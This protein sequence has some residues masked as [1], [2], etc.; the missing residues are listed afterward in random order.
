VGD[1]ADPPAMPGQE[2]VPQADA[3]ERHLLDLDRRA[4]F[5]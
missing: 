2:V 5:V 3:G 4:G 1:H